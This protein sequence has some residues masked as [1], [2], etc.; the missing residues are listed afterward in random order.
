MA[1]QR[2]IS[3][4]LTLRDRNFASGVQRAAGSTRDF[5]R[6]L[7][8]SSNQVR[9]FS[10]AATASFANVAKGIA[11]LAATY[12]GFS[13]MKNLTTEAVNAAA[14]L[15]SYRAT[16]NVV[17]GDQKKAAKTMAWAT[18]FANKTPFE[19]DSVVEATVRLQSYGLK[20]QKVLP[21]IGDMAGV[22]GKDVM[23][24]VE[25]VA[26]AQ[27]GELERMKEFGITKAMIEKKAG[28]MFKNQTVINNKGQI[29][30]QK[31]FND[32]L[33]GLMNDRFK[34]GMD[35][36]SKTFKG[37]VS[38]ITGTWKTGL[39]TMAGI[40]ASGDIVKGGLFDT[41]K[42]KAMGLSDYMSTLSENGTFEAIG[43][44]IASGV[45]IAVEKVGQLKDN[46]VNMYTSAKPGID[47]M[48]STGFP[49]IKDGIGFAVDKAT[50]FYNF[51][52]SNW[53]A[54]GPVVAGVTTSIAA[55]KIGVIAVTAAQNIWK[56]VTTATSIAAGILNGTLAVS[57]LGWVAIAIGAVVTA[58]V[59]LWQNWDTVKEKAGELWSWLKEKFSGIKDSVTSSL[60][61]IMSF[62]DSLMNK[63]ES[64]KSALSNFKMPSFSLPSIGGA[65]G[66]VAKAVIPGFAKGT[67][68][69]PGGIA[70]INERGGEIVDL[71][72]GSRVYPHDKSIQMARSESQS[73]VIENIH[74]NGSNKTSE[75]I[76]NEFI[77]LL[78]L[79]MA[80]M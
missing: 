43:S 65:V 26:D 17:M 33:F 68:Y 18:D 29:V 50:D 59:L 13:F 42:D 66:K 55:F 6:R 1:G 7:R 9:Q 35:M 78:K 11:G 27:T 77:P 72:S 54:I 25:A 4:V 79:R 49:A 32:A 45:T 8:Q 47:W 37:I 38:N 48:T 71:P 21:T 46:L 39:A 3:A 80:N 70:Q 20:A 14:G 56:G 36:Q 41:L 40:S 19:T 52:S 58:G 61:P 16:L 73:I 51:I 34:G 64:F 28:K 22:M 75:E 74:I 2:V 76:I 63:W 67:N 44:K 24:A 57:P 69:A 5:E 60:Q 23:Q 10:R 15:E 62:F 31:K 30:D 53:S 12:V